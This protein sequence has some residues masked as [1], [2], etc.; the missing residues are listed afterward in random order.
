MWGTSSTDHKLA[1]DLGNAIETT[2][3]AVV[4]LSYGGKNITEQFRTFATISNPE[5]TLE[6]LGKGQ[7]VAES[8][9]TY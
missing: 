1:G 3:I 2:K 8:P 9:D 7:L 6:C 5:Q 4:G